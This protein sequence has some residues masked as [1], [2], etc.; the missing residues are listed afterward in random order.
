[1]QD[2]VVN[3]LRPRIREH[4]QIGGP[5]PASA[6]QTGTSVPSG[7]FKTTGGGRSDYVFV[8]VANQQMWEAMISAMGREETLADPRFASAEARR[9]HVAEVTSLIEEWTSQR[10]KQ[11]AARILAGAGVPCGPVN[12]T[13][14]LLTDPHLRKREMI[15]ESYYPTRGAFLTAGCPIKLSDS[16]VEM[17]SPPTLGQH[18]GEILAEVLGY[19]PEKVEQ[20]RG[21]GVV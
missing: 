6:N 10:D 1:M 18:T 5:V 19:D 11:R 17:K 7:I 2:A 4:Q 12:D 8:H 21:E 15:V 9:A 20:L 14:D 16:P 13:G 3:L